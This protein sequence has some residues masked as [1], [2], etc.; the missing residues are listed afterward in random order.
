MNSS[1]RLPEP[2]SKDEF[3][4]L[5]MSGIRRAGETRQVV[6]DRDQ[7]RLRLADKAGMNLFLQNVYADYCSAA[8]SDRAKALSRV[9]RNWFATDK[10]MPEGFQ[11]ASND[12]LPAVRDR[13]YFASA[14]LMIRL[15]GNPQAIVP[16]QLLG[17]DLAV[18]MVYD[19]PESMRMIRTIDLEKWGVTLYEALEVARA[20]LSKLPCSFIGPEEGDGVYLS[21]TNDDYDAGRLFLLELIR[22]LR[23]KGDHI[24]MVPN[25]DTLIVTGSEDVAGINGMLALAKDALKKPRPMSGLVVR[26]DGDDWV[27][28]MPPASHPCYSEFRM[29][30][31]QTRGQ[32]Y[33]HQKELLDKL[34]QKN[35]EDIFVASFA[36]A[37]KTT[38]GTIWSYCVWSKGVLALLPKTDKV[39]IMGTGTTPLFADWDRVVA[40][41]NDLM[42]PLDIYPERYRVAGF[43]SEQQLV[44]M[45]AGPIE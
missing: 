9:V 14:E 32:A 39:V 28:W 26:F 12:L 20:N 24:A 16:Y 42:E 19:L 5:L 25:H 44:E 41:A 27:S 31:I 6:F 13:G 4:E 2:P 38:T 3:A 37:E 30:Q 29:L 8:E 1:D 15:E 36:T 21:V 35:H 33:N 45:G 43:P 11:D 17:D 40:T 22:G 10:S 7:F 34:H 23:V 18:G